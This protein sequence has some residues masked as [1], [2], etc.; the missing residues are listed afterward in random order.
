MQRGRH[1]SRRAGVVAEV[2]VLAHRVLR[3]KRRGRI[4]AV[5]D[6]SLYA[7]F[8]DDWICIGATAIGSG[9]LHVLC[10]GPVSDQFSPGQDILVVDTALVVGDVRLIGL[11]AAPVWSPKP[12]PDWTHRTLRA[13]LL[14]ANGAW[15]VAPTEE[16]FAV[17][18]CLQ[19]PSSP[20][21]VV[22]AAMPGVTA[23]RRWI[24]AGFRGDQPAPTDGEKIIE[25]IGLGPGLTPSGDDF[26]AGALLALAR[27]GLSGPRDALWN[28]LRARLDRT[29]D[30]SAA[31][32][33]SAA[34]G[35]AASAL[36]EAIDA[37]IS[38]RT[39]QIA[40][41]LASLANIGHSSGRDAFAGALVVLRT[42][43]GCTLRGGGTM[44]QS[45]IAA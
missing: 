28:V 15:R 6:R 34:S 21:P 2:G 17:F 42:V 43:D 9:P 27:L 45:P 37:A 29:N 10:E 7:V 31:H 23:L 12:P 8:D 40:P 16:G 19:L 4:A 11:D 24:E 38:G 35:Y 30:I 3:G 44:R 20:T 26:L 33:R 39:D 41:A 25:L 18:G 13:G 32:L 1:T 22:A 14:A 36:H 5:F